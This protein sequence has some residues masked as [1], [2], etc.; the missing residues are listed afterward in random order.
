M[1]QTAARVPD[2]GSRKPSLERFL[3]KAAGE[4]RVEEQEA[5]MVA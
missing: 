4:E 2:C 1:E 3:L 5:H